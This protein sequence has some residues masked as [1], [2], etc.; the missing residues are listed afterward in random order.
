VCRNNEWSSTLENL[1]P[2]NQSIT[3][4]PPITQGGF[5][6]SDREKVEALADSLEAQF[7]PV[8]VPSDPATN[9]MVHV[10]LRA[11]S[12]APASEPKLTNPVEV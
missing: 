5:A 6:L 4:P 2:E 9:A 10:A 12:F 8:S 3:P 1:D 7:Q 11:D